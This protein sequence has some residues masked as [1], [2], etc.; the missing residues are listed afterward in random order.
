MLLRRIVKAVARRHDLGATFM[1]KP[2]AEF[3]GSGM[4]IHA[5]IYDSDGNNVLAADKHSDPPE[6]T[7]RLR[8]AV[9]GLVE[10][11]NDA[12]ALYAPNPN[13]YRRFKPGA[14]APAGPSWG[15]D[16]REVALRVPSSSERNRRI[17]HRIAGADANPY[18][19]VAAVLAGIHHRR[20]GGQGYG[21]VGQPGYPAAA[22]GYGPRAVW[23]QRRD[24]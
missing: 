23:Q 6:L 3:G 13:S 4:H 19:V 17:E 21:P 11:I 14:F 15:Y 7:A 9:G 12:M 2:F 24:G 8:N 10:T 22:P 20:P 1:A 5:S 18:F 16:H